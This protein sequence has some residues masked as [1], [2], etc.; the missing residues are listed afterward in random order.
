MLVYFRFDVFVNFSLV[1]HFCLNERKNQ[2]IIATWARWLMV[3]CWSMHNSIF[4]PVP[5][6]VGKNYFWLAMKWTVVGLEHWLFCMHSLDEVWFNQVGAKRNA[7][8]LLLYRIGYQKGN[9]A[10]SWGLRM[11]RGCAWAWTQICTE[12]CWPLITHTYTLSLHELEAQVP[13]KICAI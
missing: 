7:L 9:E 3:G 4:S 1:A 11:H 12:K 8:S 13:V 10:Q 2:R 5:G 6:S